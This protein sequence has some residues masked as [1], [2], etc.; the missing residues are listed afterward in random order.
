[1]HLLRHLNSA[2]CCFILVAFSACSAQGRDFFLTIGGGYSPQGNQASLEANVIFFQRLLA[3][4]EIVEADHKVYFAD[5]F[6]SGRDLQVLQRRASKP[7]PAIKALS[8]I[9]RLSTND[10]LIYRNH[11]VPNIAGAN[12]A[13]EIRDGL[14]A[15]ASQLA[16][17]DRLIIYVTAHGGSAK[18]GKN[19]RDTSISSWGNKP[20]KMTEFSRW[21]DEL[22]EQVTIVS[23]MA[24]CYCGGFANTVFAGGDDAAGFARN[25]RC[26]FFAQQ[27]DLPAAGCR[28]DVE[29]DEE[30]SSY[31]WGAFLGESRTGKPVN[32]VDCNQ[33]GRISLA[34]AHAHA[35]IASETI[36]IPL[37]SSE[38]VLR[39]FSR[40]AGYE[41][42]G[43]S[44]TPS[45]DASNDPAD[46]SAATENK[47]AFL[48][49]SIYEIAARGRPEETRIIVGLAEKL[50]VP[51]SSDVTGFSQRYEQHRNEFRDLRRTSFR[52][53]RGSSPR[54]KLQEAVIAKWP[55]LEDPKGW[56]NTD[57]LS[58]ENQDAFLIE[59]EEMEG[60]SEFLKSNEERA[61]AREA[62]T[63]AELKQV[64]FRRLMHQLENIVLA[65]NI[66]SVASPEV[67]DHYR[68][69]V[70]AEEGFLGSR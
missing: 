7:A 38:A 6:D 40:I 56:T 49:G 26:G 37:R 35:V 13:D 36:D 47:L 31:F 68:K 18:G 60:Y 63:L 44:N 17:G 5:G 12:R 2:T 10:A 46:D 4:P 33:D 55:E 34:E 29:N 51:L 14:N 48:T 24:Q 66:A 57:L 11:Q 27:H 39:R 20:L 28:P 58:A 32:N 61:E 53:P 65:Q 1:M 45:D 22:P 43:Q 54:R 62:T 42:E 41:L 15:L 52:R 21:L 23:V 70:A 3:R 30:Y 8:D 16:A 69:L 9:F 50:D 67:V 64:K 59:L 25:V 19:S